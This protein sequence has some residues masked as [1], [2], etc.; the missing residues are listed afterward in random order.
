MNFLVAIVCPET[1]WEVPTGTV[2]DI[3]NFASLPDGE[4]EFQCRACG[5]SHLWSRKDAFLAHTLTALD[6][7]GVYEPNPTGDAPVADGSLASLSQL[8]PQKASP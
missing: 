8:S 5:R 7:Y 3:T 1:G 4:A 2:T 6:G